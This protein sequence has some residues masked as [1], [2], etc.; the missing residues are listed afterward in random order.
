MAPLYI[1]AIG[2]TG[3]RCV[4]SIT[5]L[6]AAGL[7]GKD[8]IEVLF[9]DP[10]EN[11]GN[12]SHTKKVIS[13][14]QNCYKDLFPDDK[15][16]GNN[17]SYWMQTKI[18]VR[19][20]WSPF[21]N[22]QN[23]SLGHFFSYSTNK[24]ISPE[25]SNLFEVLYTKSERDLQLD[26]GFRGRPAIG[27]A[28]FSRLDLHPDRIEEPWLSFI[29]D[30][31]NHVEEQPRIFLIGSIF[32]G[33]G[34]SGFPTLGRLI[35]NRL[36]T[37]ISNGRIKLGGL[38]SLPYFKF[39]DP[40]RPNEI[41]ARSEQ[42]MLNTQA[43]L[44]YY[45]N[46]AS[47]SVF[48]AVYLLGSENAADIQNFSLGKDAQ[49]NDP[50]FIELYGASAAR[51]F[52]FNAPKKVVL[53]QSRSNDSLGWEDLPDYSDIKPNLV[54]QTR[55]AYAWV[56]GVSRTTT[57]DRE[58]GGHLDEARQNINR[59]M[60]DGGAPWLRKYF[61]T[62]NNQKLP[63]V[64]SSRDEDISKRITEWAK[65]YL[66]WLAKVN[67]SANNVRLFNTSYASGVDNLD[68]SYE[69]FSLLDIESN[70]K[71]PYH[72]SDILLRLDKPAA[73]QVIE[74]GSLGIA[75]ALHD[76]CDSLP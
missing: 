56:T 74:S 44:R 26:V 72:L 70:V 20:S 40:S 28:I 36:E 21:G 65:N 1:I 51:H 15:P 57:E 34:A 29:A 17:V 58:Q 49:K 45:R 13:Y 18:K 9:V 54:A 63:D 75:K 30:I 47:E 48:D 12:L 16:T 67:R 43:A 46:R 50:H 23:K 38:L 68:Y 7:F 24:Q 2:G 14:Y 73:N 32:G 55:F 10:D 60:S 25:V 11:N 22:E 19:S 35:Y 37:E 62:N 66:R 41:Y 6:A 52:L 42:F 64:R 61:S 3:A 27:S 33:T 4:E 76:I 59:A 39:P 69:K 8:T 71:N 31:I 5:H 53:T